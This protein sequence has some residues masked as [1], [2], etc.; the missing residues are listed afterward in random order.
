ME[1]YDTCAQYRDTFS[2]YLAYLLENVKGVGNRADIAVRS[3]FIGVSKRVGVGGMC[4]TDCI[5][6]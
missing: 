5:T 2:I 6:I 4:Q 1:K 3:G